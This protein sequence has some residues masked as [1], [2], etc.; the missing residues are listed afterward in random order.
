MDTGESTM[1]TVFFLTSTTIIFFQTLLSASLALLLGKEKEKWEICP[2]FIGRQKIGDGDKNQFLNG[3]YPSLCQSGSSELLIVDCQSNSFS[4][5]SCAKQE[6]SKSDHLRDC[7][8]K[9]ANEQNIDHEHD[10]DWSDSEDSLCRIFE[11]LLEDSYA[12]MRH[13]FLLKSGH[14]TG[15]IMQQLEQREGT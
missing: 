9:M 5:Q 13:V 8:I 14:R 7:I 11:D 4:C 12:D 15:A 10:G 1:N 6:K 3:D 2:A